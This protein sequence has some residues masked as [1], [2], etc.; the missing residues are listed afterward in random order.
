MNIFSILKISEIYNKYNNKVHSYNNGRVFVEI[1]H[2]QI[3]SITTIDGTPATQQ[4]IQQILN[5]AISDI[6][7][8]VKSEFGF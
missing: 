6:T 7:R 1:R 8:N 3:T 4:E 5:F 2:S